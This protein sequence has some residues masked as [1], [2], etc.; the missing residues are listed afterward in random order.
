MKK[1]T[2]IIGG[3]LAIQAL[4]LSVPFLML[5]TGAVVLTVAVNAFAQERR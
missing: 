1:L 2:T 5:V 4:S 3:A